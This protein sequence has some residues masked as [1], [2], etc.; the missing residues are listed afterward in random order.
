MYL[1]CA[2]PAFLTTLVVLVLFPGGDAELVAPIVG[3]NLRAGSSSSPATRS[4][5][6]RRKSAN[7]RRV[8][9]AELVFRDCKDRFS[10]ILRGFLKRRK[11][12]KYLFN[13]LKV[14]FC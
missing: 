6:L 8:L 1:E 12:S 9:Q 4:S 5:T 2:H 7:Q 10:I 14:L 13:S 11:K 3:Q